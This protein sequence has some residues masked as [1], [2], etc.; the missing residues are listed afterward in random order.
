MLAKPK[1]KVGDLFKNKDAMDSNHYEIM[2]ILTF[3]K[4]KKL[5]ILYGFTRR[6]TETLFYINEKTLLED[7]FLHKGGDQKFKSGTHVKYDGG[8]WEVKG[9]IATTPTNK[10]LL[11]KVEEKGVNESEL[12]PCQ[13]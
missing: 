8:V 1:F 12:E 5:Q 2:E 9:I 3:R 6:R 11:K 10:Y 7:Y 4:G 13:K